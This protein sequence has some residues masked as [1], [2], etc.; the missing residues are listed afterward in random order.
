MRTIGEKTVKTAITF[1]ARQKIRIQYFLNFFSENY[2][3]GK[4][5]F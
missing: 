2:E 1:S 4:P 3:D 5:I